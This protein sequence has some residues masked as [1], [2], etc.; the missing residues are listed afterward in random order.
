MVN[1]IFSYLFCIDISEGFLIKEVKMRL[2]D[3][4][5]IDFSANDFYARELNRLVG[6]TIVVVDDEGIP[7]INNDGILH[8][9]TI[10]KD[11]MGYD[12]HQD[13][14]PKARICGWKYDIDVGYKV[15]RK[16]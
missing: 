3:S 5:F 15:A 14:C 7:H 1:I 8:L 10:L 11:L 12:F 2:H 4:D 13:M 16:P 9:C 6:K